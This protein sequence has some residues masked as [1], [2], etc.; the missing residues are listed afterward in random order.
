MYRALYSQSPSVIMNIKDTLLLRVLMLRDIEQRRY[1][2]D[3]SDLEA[4]LKEY[5]KDYNESQQLLKS[6][7]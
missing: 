7:Q 1:D 2:K 4:R 5:T 3:V 6:L